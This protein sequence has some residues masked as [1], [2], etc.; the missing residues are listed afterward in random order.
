MILNSK[1]NE[2]WEI[3]KENAEGGIDIHTGSRMVWKRNNV[4]LD[5][6]CHYSYF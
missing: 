6:H 5:T 1:D 3:D 2:V 4:R